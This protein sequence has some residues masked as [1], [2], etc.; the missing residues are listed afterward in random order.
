MVESV[1][2]S[3]ANE[4]V[5][6]VVAKTTKKGMEEPRENVDVEG[7]AAYEEFQSNWKEG[8]GTDHTYSEFE[9]KGSFSPQGNLKPWIGRQRGGIR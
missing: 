6:G 1:A 9:S 8:E 4:D 2:I 7:I 3:F 5:L